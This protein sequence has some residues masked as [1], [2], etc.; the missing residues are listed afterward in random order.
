[1]HNTSG[2]CTAVKITS[3]GESARQASVIKEYKYAPN[4]REKKHCRAFKQDLK[5]TIAPL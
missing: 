5:K 2:E 1:M 3:S 4:P